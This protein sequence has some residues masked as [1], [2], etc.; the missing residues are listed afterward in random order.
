[1]HAIL[2]WVK[3]FLILYL[4]LTI[5]MHLTAA[6]QYKKYLRFFSG[7][8]LVLMLL[9]PVMRLLGNDGRLETLISGEIFWEQL[10]SIRQ[11]TQKLEFLQ[12]DHYREK[13]ETALAGDMLA[14]AA[15][16]NLPVREVRVSLTQDYEISRVSI[17]MDLSKGQDPANIREKLKDFIKEA[18]GL[19]KDQIFVS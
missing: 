17:R 12:N 15:G 9:S 14:Q 7:I 2:N 13:Y 1:M 11:D 4:L 18:Y 16:Y 6:D 3:E 19:T 5:L 8:I 10:D